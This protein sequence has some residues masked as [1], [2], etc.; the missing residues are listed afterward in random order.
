VYLQQYP[1]LPSA[2]T[3][4]ALAD[5]YGCELSEGTLARWVEEASARLAATMAQIAEGVSR[6]RVHHAD[7]TGVR[8]GGKLHWLP[9]N[10][11]RFLTHL[12]WHKKR[13]AEALEAIGIWPR[14]QGR[15]MRDRLSSYDRYGCSMSLCGAH[16]VR[17]LT[18]REEQEQQAW[19][20][21]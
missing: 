4:E 10:R 15:A 5:L 17:E 12:A 7:E 13:G 19:A 6:S 16:L 3:G 1:L 11:T 21:T 18:Y 8:L 14:F 9:A 20:G 2:R